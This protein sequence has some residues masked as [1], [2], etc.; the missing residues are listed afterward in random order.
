MLLCLTYCG[1]MSTITLVYGVKFTLRDAE[2][3]RQQDITRCCG[4]NITYFDDESTNASM[5]SFELNESDAIEREFV[6][7]KELAKR[8]FE[9]TT[10]FASY[11]VFL[12]NDT[13]EIVRPVEIVE[14]RVYKILGVEG[15]DRQSP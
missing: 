5:M 3:L 12:Y 1:V 9:N 4:L 7:L 11:D 13:V 10:D 15:T 2:L 14:E 8:R 6:T